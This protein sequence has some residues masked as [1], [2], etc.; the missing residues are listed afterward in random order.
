MTDHKILISSQKMDKNAQKTVIHIKHLKD[1][2]FVSLETLYHLIKTSNI[3][4]QSRKFEKIVWETYMIPH[5][6]KKMIITATNG[7]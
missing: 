6:M 2:P 5:L 7:K 4:S 3:K 1:F